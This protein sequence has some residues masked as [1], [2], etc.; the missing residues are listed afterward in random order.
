M[1]MAFIDFALLDYAFG[2]NYIIGGLILSIS[3]YY[4]VLAMIRKTDFKY[5]LFTLSCCLA[6]LIVL[7]SICAIKNNEYSQVIEKS[8]IVDYYVLNQNKNIFTKG[9]FSPLLASTIP[10][11]SI[12]IFYACDCVVK[13]LQKKRM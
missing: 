11:A 12:L 6:I 13:H 10:S 5:S 2:L 9:T 3:V 7:L 4:L 8:N 1:T